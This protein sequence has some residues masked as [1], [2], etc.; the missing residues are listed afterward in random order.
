MSRAAAVGCLFLIT[1]AVACRQLPSIQ[2]GVCGN[3]VVEAGESCDG[4]GQAGASC[5][6]PGSL[7]QCHLDC[8]LRADGT[9]ATCPRGWGCAVDDVC[10]KATGRYRAQ[11]EPVPGNAFSL[12]AADF[13]GDG[14]AD[15]LSLE[16]SGMLGAAKVRVHYFDR[17]A[18]W[19]Q[20]WAAPLA[21]IALTVAQL[22]DDG[23]ADIVATDGSMGVLH[24]QRDRSLISETY[25]T[26]A[27]PNTR[28][29]II[30]P[31]RRGPV[32]DSSSLLVLLERDGVL[33]LARPDPKAVALQ[34]FAEF[35]GTIDQLAGDAAVGRVFED[36]LRYPCDDAA[37]ALKGARELSIYSVC[38]LDPQTRLAHWREPELNTIQLEPA[39]EIDRGP[40]FG[41]VDGDGHLDVLLGV[42][43]DGA[44]AG[45]P[46]S[47]YVA[48][49]D[50]RSLATAHPFQPRVDDQ[51]G[52]PLSLPLALGDFTGDGAAD[53]VYPR[54][55]LLSRRDPE[56]SDLGYRTSPARLGSSWS[57]ARIVD[58]NGNGMMDV[59]AAS[60]S[61]LDIDFFNG[62]NSEL[63]NP[64]VIETTRPVEHWAIGDFDGDL[65]EDLA[66]SETATASAPNEVAVAFGNHAGPPTAPALVARV[67]KVEQIGW[68]PYGQSAS[69]AGLFITYQQLD[70]AGVESGALAQFAPIG[71]RSLICG[72]DLTSFSSDGSLQSVPGLTLTTGAFT[73][74]D[75]QDAILLGSDLNTGSSGIWLVPDLRHRT[76]QPQSMGWGL[77]QRIKPLTGI[78]ARAPVA[79]PGIN[80]PIENPPAVTL[81][82]AA[83]DLDQ[84]GV[85]ELVVAAPDPSA[86][87][88]LLQS[89][90]VVGL[91]RPTLATHEALELDEA[92]TATSQLAVRDLDGDHAA[93]IVLLTGSAQGPRKL[94]VFWNDGSGAFSQAKSA[95]IA[96]RDAVPQAFVIFQ[97]TKSAPIEIAYVTS[98]RVH[99]LSVSPRTRAF[100]GAELE[101]TLEAG[102][103]ITAADVDGD[104]VTD[105]AV[106]D[107]GGVRVLRAELE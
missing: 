52:T 95:S 98:D 24:G 11:A 17:E 39:G 70:R 12:L 19:T 41:D 55:F 27:L 33:S 9:R 50:G 73:A 69:V 94:L 2:A 54:A 63:L 71:E 72:V 10:R 48:F 102:T 49:G 65:I 91:D 53:F 25:P 79:M 42:R 8:S 83:G 68:L 96:T 78:D 81:L 30:G 1:S 82:L 36:A 20:T 51:P 28:V 61:K 88:C 89:A 99:V 32:D 67:P 38:E 106:A 75:Q 45:D 58:L 103:G 16:P 74:A 43:Q 34:S 13:D 23:R 22:S 15:I 90:D 35:A 80:L 104:G 18:Q 85:D 60:N 100:S 86:T 7:L 6:P 40:L 57:E 59:V 84:D 44:A 21:L 66:L 62:T 3:A 92:C 37:F 5:R 29:R 97:P 76:G 101:L 107:A 64:F 31:L 56:A 105:L 77:D 93:D 4:F 14:R 26:Y 46:E 87:H 47:L